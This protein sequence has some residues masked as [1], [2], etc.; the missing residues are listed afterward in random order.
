MTKRE[1]SPR[2][3]PAP[4]GLIDRDIFCSLP[5]GRPTRNAMD[6]ERSS[7]EHPIRVLSASADPR[8]NHSRALL[9]RRHGFE[10]ITSE[11]TEHAHGQLDSLPFDVLIFGSTL[12]H[13]ACWQLAEVFRKHN[14]A[15]R[16]IEILPDSLASPKNQPDALVVSAEEPSRLVSTIHENLKPSYRDAEDEYWMRLCSQ[17]AVERD[18][19]KLMNLLQEINRILNEKEE[20][21]KRRPGGGEQT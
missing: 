21:R 11:S 18:P 9:L 14:A 13:K 12:A 17:A 6:P 3:N 4:G 2:R 5:N 20:R 1:C 16:I 19:Q 10:V 8:L 15:G 7:V